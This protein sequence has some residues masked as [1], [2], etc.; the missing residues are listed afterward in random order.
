MPTLRRLSTIAVFAVSVAVVG[1]GAVGVAS[2]EITPPLAPATDSV[3]ISDVRDSDITSRGEERAQLAAAAA[4]RN[5]SLTDQATA[6]A[7]R[8]TEV[9]LELRTTE[10]AAVS[11]ALS[12][13]QKRLEAEAERQKFIEKNGFDPDTTKPREMARQM[14]KTKFGWGEDQFTCYDN[15]IMRES[16]WKVTADNPFSSAYGIPQALPGR[17]MASEG[18]D[19]KTN[20]VT[21]IRWGLKYVKQRYGTPCAA[22]SFKRARGWY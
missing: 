15:I 4:A 1:A 2:G 5:A 19:W 7:E 3:A 11:E 18:A 22:W 12:K 6:I 20:P 8:E 16:L 13:E 14:M 10:Q 21:Q 9:L 17:R